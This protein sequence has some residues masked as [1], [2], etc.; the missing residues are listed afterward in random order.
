W[1][2]LCQGGGTYCCDAC[3]RVVCNECLL[4]PPNFVEVILSDQVFFICPGCHDERDRKA[5]QGCK[6]AFLPYDGFFTRTDN[7]RE[8]PVLP[9]PPVIRHHYGMSSRSEVNDSPL[10][11]IHLHLSGMVVAGTP[12]RVIYENFHS[13]F[14]LKNLLLLELEFDCGTAEK[15]AAH[16]RRMAEV[17]EDLRMQG[18]GR[19][20]LFISTHSEQTRGDLF[21]G[22]DGQPEK[23]FSTE[24]E[25]VCISAI[26]RC[27]T[28][29]N[30]FAVLP[31]SG[32]RTIWQFAP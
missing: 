20:V 12:P 8:V 14:D 10:A 5:G 24:V 32:A 15:V 19:T 17:A 6:R 30:C 28:N 26:W 31:R 9:S 2:C 25:A 18:I 3:N 22:R 13:Y 29:L 21:I 27:S 4:V 11:I 16:Q 1:C 23:Y 7:G